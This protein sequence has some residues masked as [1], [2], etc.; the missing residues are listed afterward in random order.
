MSSFL[1]FI[2]M[3]DCHVCT[4]W[5]SLFWR[6]L[7]AS[8][9]GVFYPPLFGSYILLFGFNVFIVRVWYPFSGAIY[10]YLSLWILMISFVLLIS[11]KHKNSLIQREHEAHCLVF[12][13]ICLSRRLLCTVLFIFRRNIF[14]L[15]ARQI[16]WRPELGD[17]MILESAELFGEFIPPFWMGHLLESSDSDAH[18]YIIFLFC[19]AKDKVGGGGRCGCWH[20]QSIGI[21]GNQHPTKT[22][23]YKFILM[24]EGSSKT[25]SQFINT[26][27][28][29]SAHEKKCFLKLLWETDRMPTL[30]PNKTHFHFFLP[31][32]FISY[33]L[34]IS[35]CLMSSS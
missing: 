35:V 13:L 11:P 1:G 26:S 22:L 9:L 33:N 4:V 2:G 6:F 15:D 21:S 16:R 20:C 19:C 34:Y 25:I 31:H 12:T 8:S 23:D 10:L 17:E 14:A 5:C 30:D 27:G 29:C 7:M 32:L 18:L 28:K 3:P 24:S